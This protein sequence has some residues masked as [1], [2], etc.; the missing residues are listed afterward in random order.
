[1][2]PCWIPGRCDYCGTEKIGG[3]CPIGKQ[4][5]EGEEVEFFDLA[6]G[7]GYYWTKRGDETVVG[8]VG[9][10]RTAELALEGLI[11]K[12]SPAA[13]EAAWSGTGVL[14]A[15]KVHPIEGLPL[16]ATTVPDGLGP[17]PASRRDARIE[18]AQRRMREVFSPRN[19][20]VGINVYQGNE[21]WYVAVSTL[22]GKQTHSTDGVD[23]DEII[24]R[25]KKTIA[26]A[27]GS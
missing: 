24:E 5:K 6:H 23:F 8:P 13:L 4:L 14:E 9:P 10:Y 27:E 7:R 21:R 26:D 17:P 1:M 11:R 25:M 12:M 3:Y 2:R 15:V 22:G 20:V 16:T 18:A 19:I